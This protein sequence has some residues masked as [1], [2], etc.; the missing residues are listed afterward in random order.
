MHKKSLKK[1]Y[2]LRY[3]PISFKKLTISL[4]E[5]ELNRSFK[6][7]QSKYLF[8]RTAWLRQCS[9]MCSTVN[10]ESPQSHTGGDS[11]FNRY[12]CVRNVCPRR[13]R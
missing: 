1:N 6:E 8:L 4:Q 3:K 12:E 9:K 5:I 13:S 2:S 7:E 10:G 11:L